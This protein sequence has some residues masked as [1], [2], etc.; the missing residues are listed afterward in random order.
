MVLIGIS[1]YYIETR[2]TTF[3]RR[4]AITGRGFRRGGV[5]IA[6]LLVGTLLCPMTLLTANKTRGGWSLLLGVVALLVGGAKSV[7]GGGIGFATDLSLQDLGADHLG[8]KVFN[9]V[10]GEE[11]V[12]DV[13]VGLGELCEDR[14]CKHIIIDLDTVQGTPGA[15]IPENIQLSLEGPIVD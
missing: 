8:S 1:L 15:E 13:T 11:S 6:F 12:R 10:D 5:G 7:G 2:F 4:F 14:A 9:L 3:I